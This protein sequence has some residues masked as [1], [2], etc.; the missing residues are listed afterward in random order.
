MCIRDS[1]S[2]EPIMVI[3]KL[4]LEAKVILFDCRMRRGRTNNKNSTKESSHCESYINKDVNECEIVLWRR[5]FTTLFCFTKELYLQLNILYSRLCDYFYFV[6]LFLLVIT[7]V[8]ILSY[9]NGPHQR[10]LEKAEWCLYWLGLGILS[11]IGLG[12]GLHTFLLY[13]GPHIASV[14]LAAYECGSL[15]FPEPPYPKVI[16]CP[17]TVDPRWATNT[18]NIMLKVYLEAI[19]WGIGTAVGELPPYFVAR[20]ARLSSHSNTDSEN[21]QVDFDLELTE[22]STTL[23]SL[24]AACLLYTSRCV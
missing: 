5:P 20:A 12:T 11:S 23:N 10:Y 22:K 6:L 9:I 24:E 21:A 14:T 17:N 4:L 15:N 19:M 16:L 13:L 3:I 18:F 1:C 7:S 2:F 8:V